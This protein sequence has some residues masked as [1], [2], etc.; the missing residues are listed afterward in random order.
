[1]S[2]KLDLNIVE[3][4]DS[5]PDTIQHHENRKMD[6][7]EKIKRNGN[8]QLL[9]VTLIIIAASFIGFLIGLLMMI[10]LPFFSNLTILPWIALILS[11]YRENTIIPECCPESKDLRGFK[12]LGGLY[13][14]KIH[15][16]PRG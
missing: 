13:S 2:R 5:T 15:F 4:K 10:I 3:S 14:V 9:V 11:L 16:H 8:T 12:N 1:M 6:E 7:N